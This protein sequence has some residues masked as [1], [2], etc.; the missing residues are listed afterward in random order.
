MELSASK[1]MVC[2]FGDVLHGIVD[3]NLLP[4]TL[5]TP[6]GTPVL[7]ESQIIRNFVSVFYG[8]SHEIQWDVT[9][10]TLSEN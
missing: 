3:Y 7:S 6:W 8:T 1:K 2:P 4:G 10:D 5:G 9:R